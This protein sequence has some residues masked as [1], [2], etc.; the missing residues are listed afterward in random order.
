MASETVAEDP[1]PQRLVGHSEPRASAPGAA[2]IA[3][4]ITPLNTSMVP[5]A[6]ED[7]RISLDVD[8]STSISLVSTFAFASAIA[9][10][11]GG[12]AADRIGPR[13]VIMAGFLMM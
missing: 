13:T 6:L 7:V 8:T 11:L 10:P 9:Q 5:V 12:L 3:S 1:S 2:A 4:L